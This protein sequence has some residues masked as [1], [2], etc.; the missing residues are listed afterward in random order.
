[1]YTQSLSPQ[2]YPYDGCN[3]SRRFI[4]HA[5]ANSEWKVPRIHSENVSENYE[6]YMVSFQGETQIGYGLLGASKPTALIPGP[7]DVYA[8]TD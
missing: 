7:F 5:D 4:G 3:P 6:R 2:Q 1:M 8:L